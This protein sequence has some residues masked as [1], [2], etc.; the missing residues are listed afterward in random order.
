MLY[1]II[2]RQQGRTLV[3]TNAIS[4]A[5]R[6]GAL[7]GHLRVPCGVLHAAMQQRQR[8]TALDRFRSSGKGVLV[9]T[10][11]AARGIDVQV[12]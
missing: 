4:A 8:L 11:V 9:A 10:D 2:T 5:R 6:L 1:Y 3:F 12:G 7:M